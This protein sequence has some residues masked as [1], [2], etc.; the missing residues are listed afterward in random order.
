MVPL[1][2]DLHSH[3]VFSD[4][5]V[6]PSIRVKEAWQHGLDA[7]AI[8][9]HIEYRP[10]KKFV[11]GDLNEANKLAQKAAKDR[12]I[13][14]VEGTEITRRKPLGHLNALFIKDATKMDV[15]DP[16]EAIDEA[17]SQGAFILWN[18]PGWPDDESKLYSVHKKLIKESKI[19]GIEVFNQY[20]YYPASFDWCNDYNLA[21]VGNSDIH[22]LTSINFGM[23][24]IRPMTIA[25]A[26]E[27]SSDA[28]KEALF[29][30]RTVALFN[31]EI[32]GREE[33]VKKLVKAS[34]CVTNVGGDKIEVYN[35]SDISYNMTF[36]D[37]VYI[38]P[39][40]KTVRI[41]MPKK[42]SFVVNNCHVGTG[43]KLEVDAEEL[44]SID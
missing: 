11:L 16:L 13:I 7:I 40:S 3:T 31:G 36:D 18:H 33:L 1:K 10:H 8:T 19:H 37:T 27:K 41:T 9:D 23:D 25:F 29:A 32:A 5:A 35:N 42:G 14:V 12:G 21:Y 24:A 15:K 28:L 20:E 44:F 34:L 30:K 2:C 22:T 26:T 39:A 38:F 6:M 17:I 4:G 43:D